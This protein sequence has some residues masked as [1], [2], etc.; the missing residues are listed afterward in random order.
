MDER[1]EI[2]ALLG[3]VETFMRYNLRHQ[4]LL[5]DDSPYAAM[6]DLRRKWTGC[7]SCRLHEKRTHQV[8]GRGPVPAPVAF[9][10]EGPGE[11]EDSQGIPFVGPAGRLLGEMLGRLGV[12][13][14]SV[15]ITNV[16]KCRPPQ[17]RNPQ[18]D[19]VI[20]CSPLVGAELSLVSPRVIVALGRVAANFLLNTDE[21]LGVLRGEVHSW[22]GTPVVVTYH[23]AYVLRNPGGYD[24]TM[25][26]LRRALDMGGLIG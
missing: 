15:Y 6:Q 12:S 11:Q 13:R 17:N 22:E 19:E 14:S 24:R 7:I 23:P 16:V 4:R 18:P 5:V 26:D 10:G 21:P 2:T 3:A 20:A 25:E 9:V 8:F 1:D